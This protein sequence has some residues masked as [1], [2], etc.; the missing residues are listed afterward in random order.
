MCKNQ[1]HSIYQQSVFRRSG[2][3]ISCKSHIAFWLGMPQVHE[4]P[5]KNACRFALRPTKLL[6][7]TNI[8]LKYVQ[9]HNLPL[10]EEHPALVQP[11][12]CSHL[13]QVQELTKR[14]KTQHGQYNQVYI[15]EF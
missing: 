13:P 3:V 9:K 15:E 10:Q 7:I 6:D 5:D 12:W 4:R 14:F 1:F 8:H 2:R 11:T